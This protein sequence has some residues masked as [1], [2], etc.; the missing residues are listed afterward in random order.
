MADLPLTLAFAPNERVQPLL[1]GTV[2]PEGIALTITRMDPAEI[3][4]RQL[5]FAEFDVSEMSLSS[6]LIVTARGDSPWVGLPIFTTRRFF[7]TGI[8]VRADAGIAQPAD[9]R[10]KRVGVP[11]YQQTAAVWCRG[12]LQHEFGVA[13]TEMEWYMERTVEDSHGGATGFQP[14]PGVS[15]RYIPPEQNIASLMLTGELDATVFFVARGTRHNRSVV[16]LSRHPRVRPLFPDPI[17]ESRRYYQKTGLFPMNH[18]VVVRRTVLERHPWVAL[19]LYRAFQAAKEQA[20][21]ET[22][23]LVEPYL[24]LGLLPA[25]A[26]A[27]FA[28]DPF[29][30]GLRAN[31]HAL[32][33]LT[34]YASEQGLTPRRVA[35][36]EVFAPS[37][38][39]L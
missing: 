26:Q 34:Q 15:L 31:R 20:A 25:E 4:W 2:R 28:T 12:A 33:T 36:E 19:N 29:P 37:T 7:H 22:R 11:E 1:D 14:P 17:A 8:L 27:A 9:L 30:Y 32:E 35:L 24:H 13:P 10:G 23:A 18:T 38:L 21:A 5:H 39:D 6:L 16:D 3:F